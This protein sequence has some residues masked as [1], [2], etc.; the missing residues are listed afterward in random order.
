VATQRTFECNRCKMVITVA[1]SSTPPKKQ[2]GDCPKD[3][4]KKGMHYWRKK[5]RRGRAD[6]DVLG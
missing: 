3:P 5:P 4:F 1:S 6:G 2:G